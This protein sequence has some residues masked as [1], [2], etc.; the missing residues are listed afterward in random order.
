[1]QAE[2]EP[3][4][5]PPTLREAA[6]SLA[7]KRDGWP[8]VPRHLPRARLEQQAARAASLTPARQPAAA[9]PGPLLLAAASRRARP[10]DPTVS[11]GC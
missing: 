3:T 7:E 6:V 8:I 11:A 4:I 5:V 9:P 2:A 1:V 10:G